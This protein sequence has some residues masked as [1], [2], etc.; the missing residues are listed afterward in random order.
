M[1]I[2]EQ[3]VRLRLQVRR[4]FCDKPA[5]PRRTFAEPL[6][7]LVPA[8]AQRTV[9]LTRTLETIGFALGSAAGARLAHQL[10]MRVSGTTLLH[11]IRTTPMRQHPPPTVLGVGDFALCKGRTYGTTLLDLERCCP[12][13]LLPDRTAA[14]LATWLPDH[15]TVQI[16]TRDRALDYVRGATDGAP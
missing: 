16:I 2:A 10:H 1:P 7:D 6:P 4:F 5:C 14:T 12:I 9:R 11:I 15:P 13:D 8:H 3:A